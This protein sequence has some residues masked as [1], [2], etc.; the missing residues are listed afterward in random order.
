MDP[1]VYYELQVQL[2]LDNYF[3]TF[4]GLLNCKKIKNKKFGLFASFAMCQS[5]IG[6]DTLNVMWKLYRIVTL[7]W[8]TVWSYVSLYPFIDIIVFIPSR[9]YR[10]L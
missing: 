2:R 8:V 4:D 7:V 1:T 10:V 5:Y 3:V 6:G 9:L